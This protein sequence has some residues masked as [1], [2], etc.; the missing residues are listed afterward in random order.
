ME[1]GDHDSH[2]NSETAQDKDESEATLEIAVY[3][4]S[5]EEIGESFAKYQSSDVHIYQTWVN[6]RALRRLGFLF[7]GGVESAGGLFEVV[8]MLLAIVLVVA[9]FAFYHLV[10]FFI[11]FAVLAVLSG[12][13]A[14]KYLRGTFIEGDESKIDLNDLVPFVKEQIKG[15]YFVEVQTRSGEIES[16]TIKRSNRDTMLF[17]RGIHLSLIVSTLFFVIE[18]IYRLFFLDWLT[19][20]GILLVFGLVFLG[21]VFIMNSGAFLRRR[22]EKILEDN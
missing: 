1:A 15:G 18:V 11:V 12:G 3:G 10:I 16:E 22:F 19:N 5:K 7:E 21:G 4:G 2:N 6:I 8:I 20:T 14:L 9:M 17:K 13:V